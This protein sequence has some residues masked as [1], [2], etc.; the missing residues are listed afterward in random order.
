MNPTHSPTKTV[1]AQA[2]QLVLYRRALHPELFQLKD[3]KTL[4]AGDFEFEAWLMPGSHALR[5]QHRI[6]CISELVTDKD[7][8]LP[9]SGAVATVPC[10]GEHDFEHEFADGRVCYFATIQ[11]ETLND[12]L[13][14][15]TYRDMKTYVADTGAM[16][17]EW[18]LPGAALAG[19]KCLSV[20]EVHRYPREIHAQSFHL[21]ADSGLVLRTQ[22]IVEHE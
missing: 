6:M 2:Y 22:T 3:R 13:Y 21:I 5:F 11:T 15:S 19:G 17:H 18:S 4:R 8:G 1:A 20:L 14:R 7:D 16:A 9:T 10:A 12:A